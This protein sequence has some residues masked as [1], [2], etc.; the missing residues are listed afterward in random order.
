MITARRTIQNPDGI[1]AYE[2]GVISNG[3]LYSGSSYGGKSNYE[4]G[5]SQQV[6]NAYGDTFREY[7]GGKVQIPGG[8]VT[9]DGQAWISENELMN[10]LQNPNR[11]KPK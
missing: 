1:P 2:I 11:P 4:Q 10:L 5:R 8:L 3:N 7:K 6:T 9:Y